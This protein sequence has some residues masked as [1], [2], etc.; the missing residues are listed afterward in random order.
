VTHERRLGAWCEKSYAQ[1]VIVCLRGQHEGGITIVEFAGDG[2]HLL[3]AQHFGAK[4]DTCWVA[5]EKLPRER[6][7]LKDLYGS[8]HDLPPIGR[9][10]HWLTQGARL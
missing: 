10:P 6:V 9:G 4:Y 1:I 3:I 8:R 5:R 2:E 7:D